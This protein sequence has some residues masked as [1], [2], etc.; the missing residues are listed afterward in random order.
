[1]ITTKKDTYLETMI[2]A[3]KAV[4]LDKAANEDATQMM[5]E[6]L[7]DLVVES[8]DYALSADMDEA[9]KQAVDIVMDLTK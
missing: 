5:W 3:Y 2:K 1:M 6:N 4:A 7:L 9:Y 8:S